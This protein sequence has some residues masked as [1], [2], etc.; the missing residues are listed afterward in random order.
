[1]TDQPDPQ[2]TLGNSEPIE[3]REALAGIVR[4]SLE[5]GGPLANRA[6][7]MDSAELMKAAAISLRTAAS[8]LDE[9]RKSIPKPPLP[10]ITLRPPLPKRDSGGRSRSPKPWPTIGPELARDL[11]AA[12]E[13]AGLDLTEAARQ[14]DI[15]TSTLKKLEADD[16]C[17]RM[18]KA[19]RMA[20]AMWVPVSLGGRL[21]DVSVPG[22]EASGT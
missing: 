13:A 14:C 5:T 20:Q 17:P 15:S 16:H 11:T 10:P 2:P 18:P 1:M 12:R 19:E 6:I 3:P 22:Y 8:A 7:E 21:I 4:W 9:L